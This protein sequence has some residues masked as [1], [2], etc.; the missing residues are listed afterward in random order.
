MRES[1]R[2]RVAL[3]KMLEAGVLLLSFITQNF[4]YA[5]LD[6]RAALL[7]TA[8]HDRA[9][10]D[11]G[12]ALA[13]L[14][15]FAVQSSTQPLGV[16]IQD[17]MRGKLLMAA[18]KTVNSEGIVLDVIESLTPDERAKFKTD[19]G[20]RAMAVHSYGELSELFSYLNESYSQYAIELNKEA[21]DV[22]DDR[23]S[24]QWC[25]LLLYLAGAFVT[26]PAFVLEWKTA[27]Q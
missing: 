24:A 16:D 8:M 14:Q 11:K 22:H 20:Q 4:Y 10:I 17:L 25:Y 12:A 18:T 3:L 2:K 1:A 15:Y 9:M 7:A 26:L 21:Q 23:R 5:R 6:A 19:L 27:E 13:E